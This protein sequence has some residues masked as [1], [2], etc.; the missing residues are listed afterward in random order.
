M[1]RDGILL[2]IVWILCLA[3]T[4]NSLKHG[5]EDNPDIYLSVPQLIAKYGY[6]IEV[7]HVTTD[8]GYILELHRI[9][10][11]RK[12]SHNS[13]HE[14][15]LNSFENEVTGKMP[16][17]MQHGLMSSSS[18]WVLGPVDKAPAYMMANAGYDV[19][20]GN[21]RGNRYSKNHTHL[22]PKDKEFW[23]FSWDEMAEH[24]IPAVIDYI[25]EET[26]HSQLYYI[27][28]SMG[29]TIF[30][31]CM[32]SHPQ[33]NKKIKAMFGLGPVATVKHIISPIKYL[34]PF[35]NDIHILLN[36][37]GDYEFLPYN[38]KYVEWT[39]F[40]CTHFRYEKLMCRDALFFLCGFDAHQFNMTWLPVIL[41][42]GAE[43]TSTMTVVHYAQ[44]VNTG[45]FE[46]YDFGKSENI[47][48]YHQP[49]PPKYNLKN[50]TAPVALIW[51]QNDWLADPE[52]IVYLASELP[53]LVLNIK[54]PLPDFNHMDFIWGIDA[55]KLVYKRILKYM[56]FF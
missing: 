6:P 40:V 11:G 53:N 32:S 2:F 37:L 29:T 49:T 31:G 14:P 4:G 21:A 3:A 7:H 28:H 23:D 34:A 8:D 18:S 44:E 41:S 56:K 47:R 54:M 39:E 38:R 9:P 46:H 33:Y 52:D 19:W 35:A 16:V 55:D 17:F 20:L 48:R 27:G 51:A 5:L 12:T 10:H 50:V 13:L 22:S 26:K 36:L 45:A 43:G 15:N 42:H 24:D 25:L 1:V 30:Y